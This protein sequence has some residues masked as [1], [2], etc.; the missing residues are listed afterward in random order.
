MTKPKYKDLGSICI[1]DADDA[2]I[3]VNCFLEEIED[4]SEFN[5][6]TRS[7]FN[8]KYL[9]W[10]KWTADNFMPRKSHVNIAAYI[11]MAPEKDI[12]LKLVKK[13]VVPLY[14]AA[15]GNLRDLGDNYYW[16]K[17]K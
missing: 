17:E 3:P 9:G 6:P 16:K 7:E 11:V 4:D 13:H 5:D 8:P 15:L 10:F 12:I 14:E 1:T 2:N